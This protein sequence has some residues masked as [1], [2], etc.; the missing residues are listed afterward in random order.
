MREQLIFSEKNTSYKYELK[1]TEHVFN[2]NYPL[3]VSAM[4]HRFCPTL[5]GTIIFSYPRPHKS[6]VVVWSFRSARTK[7]QTT[8]RMQLGSEY[9]RGI[10]ATVYAA[11]R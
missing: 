4:R 2:Q 3:Q 11:I 1:S 9:L 5:N 6:Q 8:A 7:M 10:E